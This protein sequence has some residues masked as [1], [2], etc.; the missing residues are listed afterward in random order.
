MSTDGGMDKEHMVHIHNGILLSHKNEIVPFEATWMDLGS[1]YWVK[2]DRE[3]QIS[4]AI[5]YIWNLKN[6]TSGVTDIE[7]KLMVTKWEMGGEG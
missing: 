6:G 1:S 5:T 3:R 7:S 4:Y 2:W